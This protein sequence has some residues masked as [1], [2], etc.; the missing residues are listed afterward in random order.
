MRS[1]KKSTPAKS[2]S[3]KD[4]SAKTPPPAPPRG[5]GRPRKSDG[6]NVMQLIS[7][8]QI[9]ERA[10]QL[11]KVEPL[12]EISVVGLAREFGV[13]T[14]LIHYYVGSREDLLSG[15]INVFFEERVR[16][17]GTLNGNW[18]AD[19]EKHARMSYGIMVE[20]GG[21]VRYLMTHNRFRIFQQ[22]A[23]GQ[24]DYGLIY[25]NRV[26]GIFLAGGFTPEQAVMAHHLLSLYI[27]SS[28]YAAVSRQLPGEHS[29][30]IAG[31]IR[32]TS[33]DNYPAVHA[34]AD[35]YA[36]VGAEAAFERG[37]QFYLDG[38]AKQLR[39][40]KRLAKQAPAAPRKPLRTLTGGRRHE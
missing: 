1:S 15:V 27:M 2:I 9:I 40:N 21:V 39:E 7:R 32:A 22:V 30:Y 16:R 18:R 6:A 17:L 11:A 28:A 8:E 26:M 20:F 19:L 38:L 14:A 29:K 33:M 35:S 31:Q 37:L 34:V 10:I 3:A 36:A 12:T 25:V 24:P 5:R 13:T 23:P 4:T